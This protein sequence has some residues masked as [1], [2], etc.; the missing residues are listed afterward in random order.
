ML[1]LLHG[2]SGQ[3]TRRWTRPGGEARDITRYLP[4]IVVMPD[5]GRGGW[6]SDWYNGGAFGPPRWETYHLKQLVPWVES[7]YRAVG[8]RAAAAPWPAC[9]W[10]G[11]AR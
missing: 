11:S 7:H 3:T 10:A 9:R 1:L 8:D 5:G 4:V 6:Y 2:A